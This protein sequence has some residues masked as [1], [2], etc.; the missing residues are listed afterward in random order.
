MSYYRARL[1]HLVAHGATTAQFIE[2]DK[3]GTYRQVALVPTPGS[4]EAALAAPEPE[5][6]FG[7][8]RGGGK[9]ITSLMDWGKDIGRGY[10]SN[11]R[12]IFLRVNVPGFETLVKMCEQWIPLIWPGTRYLDTT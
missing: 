7:G 6:L 3:R 9:T 12:G 2:T 5:V 10:G 4:S 8:P 1:H 11:Y